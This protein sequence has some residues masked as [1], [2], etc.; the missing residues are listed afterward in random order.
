MIVDFTNGLLRYVA[1]MVSIGVRREGRRRGT[2][3]LRCQVSFL[4]PHSDLRAFTHRNV[5]P[6][7]SIGAFDSLCEVQSDKASVEITSPFDG[8][9]KEILVQEGQ[10]AKVGDSLCVI[11]TD[12]DVSEDS[13]ESTSVPPADQLSHHDQKRDASNPPAGSEDSW[14]ARRP[15]PLD[16]N[17]PLVPESKAPP[18]QGMTN[19]TLR[20]DVL[21]L[22]AVRHLA[23]QSGVDIAL[24]AP[25]SGKNGRVEHVD[26]E[27][28]LAR[29]KSAGEQLSPTTLPPP[30]EEDVVIELGR[31]RYGMWKAM[32]KVRKQVCSAGVHLYDSFS[33]RVW[34]SHIL[35]EFSRPGQTCIAHIRLVIQPLSTLLLYITFFP[36]SMR[37][38]P[39]T[40]FLHHTSNP[41]YPSSLP[42]RSSRYPKFMSRLRQAPMTK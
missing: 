9:L 33:S 36:F 42:H 16:P 40:I 7:S 20:A 27:R 14:V 29:G 30:A 23:R 10:V 4:V 21:A 2:C 35:G 34:K 39:S 12:E 38:Y 17:D 26:V 8:T 25:G 5:S 15:H 3:S 37:I 19:S 6:Q 1:F 11:E 41:P 28:Y 18:P 24:L 22:P 32:Q 31:T 13:N